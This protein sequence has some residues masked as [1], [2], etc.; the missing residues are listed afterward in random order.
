MTLGAIDGEPYVIHDTSGV[1]YNGAGGKRARVE[2][3]EVSVSPLTP[4]LFGDDETYV[5]RMTS[6]VRIRPATD[7]ANAKPKE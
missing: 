6:I 2:L 5:D 3:N 4:L 1:S 7:S